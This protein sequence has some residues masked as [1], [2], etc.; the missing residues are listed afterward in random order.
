MISSSPQT[1]G[2]GSS[3]VICNKQY[4]FSEEDNIAH[5]LN[6]AETV[7]NQ[8]E[9]ILRK[10]LYRYMKIEY[11]RLM[12]FPYNYNNSYTSLYFQI[13]YNLS[14]ETSNLQ[15]DDQS[16]CIGPV[17]AKPK[18]FTYLPP[19]VTVTN[20]QS[21]PYNFKEWL[22]TGIGIV[23]MPI[24]LIY[25]KGTASDRQFPCEIQIKIHFRGGNIVTAESIKEINSVL[26]KK[27]IE[28]N[29]KKLEEVKEDVK[30]EIEEEEI[31]ETSETIERDKS[32]LEEEE[33]KPIKETI[34]ANKQN[35]MG[36]KKTIPDLKIRKT[37][38]K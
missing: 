3:T 1:L 21:V 16:K 25:Q 5:T 19:N 9:F 33:G 14:P 20:F 31:K 36:S 12:F 8:P 27:L 11:I 32:D 7:L 28:T 6:L 10:A 4:K 30:E 37:S 23:N 18:S 34:G 2:Y 24:V 15:E 17:L 35:F 13:A 38:K 29:K 26:N 22:P